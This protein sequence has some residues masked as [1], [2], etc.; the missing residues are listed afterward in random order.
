M[1]KTVSSLLRRLWRAPSPSRGY[2]Y[3]AAHAVRLR[4]LQEDFRRAAANARAIGFANAKEARPRQVTGGRQKTQVATAS[5]SASD[6]WLTNPANP[7]FAASPLNPA[8]PASPIS[9][10]NSAN[11]PP[12][13]HSGGHGG[14]SPC[15]PSHDTSGSSPPHHHSDHGCSSSPTDWGSSSSSSTDYG[16]SSSSFDTNNSGSS[17]P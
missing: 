6:D 16:S 7:L 4:E 11:Q 15:P 10:L 2:D 8:N 13:H 17:W 9:P 1:F 3:D 12:P 5:A 14:S